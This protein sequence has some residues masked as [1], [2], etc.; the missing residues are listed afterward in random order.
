MAYSFHL[1]LEIKY[2]QNLIPV[3]SILFSL[4]GTALPMLSEKELD[5]IKQKYTSLYTLRVDA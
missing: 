3:M 2:T 1:F 4:A 5:S